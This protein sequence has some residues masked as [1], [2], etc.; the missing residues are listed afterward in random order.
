MSQNMNVRQE[1]YKFHN[2]ACFYGTSQN[3]SMHKMTMLQDPYITKHL[4]YKT[5][6]VTNCLCY[7][8]LL[9]HE[10]HCET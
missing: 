7:K 9:L 5:F 2:I 1:T 6:I 8:Y 10:V 4:C 3:V